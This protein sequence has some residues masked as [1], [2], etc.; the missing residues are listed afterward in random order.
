VREEKMAKQLVMFAGTDSAEIR[1]LW[2]TDC[3]AGGTYELTGIAGAYAGGLSP[4]DFTSFNGEVLFSGLDANDHLGLWI[5]NGTA[6]GTYEL[7]G[8]SNASANGLMPP[9][10][11]NFTVFNGEVLFEGVN[12][13]GNFGLWET[14]GTA[15]G[16]SEIT[17]ISNAGPD[18]GAGGGGLYPSN[19]VVFNNEV[20]FEGRDAASQGNTWVTN[21][22]AA[23]TYEL[24]GVSNSNMNLGGGLL[25]PSPEKNLGGAHPPDFTLFNGELLFNGV[26]AALK[27]GLWAT[28]GTVAGTH[29]ITGGPNAFGLDPEDLTVFKNMVLFDGLDA[30][31]HR[32]LWVSDGTAAGTHELTGIAG[33]S[34][35]GAGFSP[36]DLTV[37]KG[38]V[39]FEGVDTAGQQGLWVT[40]GTAAGTHELTG[41]KGASSGGLAPSDFTVINKNEMLFE[42]FDSTAGVSGVSGLWLTNGTVAGTHEITGISGAFTGTTG[43]NDQAGGLNPGS[44]TVVSL[45]AAGDPATSSDPTTAAGAVGVSADAFHFAADLGSDANANANV[46]TDPVVTNSQ[47]ADLAALMTD[48]HHGLAN[49]VMPYD[50]HETTHLDQVAQSHLH[51][52]IVHLV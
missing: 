11:P 5:T 19:F 30:G 39:F 13:T 48:P 36:Q 33:A 17:G 10:A 35:S 21:G 4:F 42:G 46:N 6:A 47:A 38:K 15:A 32:G 44:L 27:D 8:I 51:A 20:L 26:D 52:S 50:G 9:L 12:A 37:F 49:T 16:T 23:G 2:L 1:G 41:I 7:T 14:N 22:T 28:D 34:T 24:T 3:T 43:P 29:E 45:P 31:D 25:G 18:Q 40:D